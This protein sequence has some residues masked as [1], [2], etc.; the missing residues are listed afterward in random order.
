M[1]QL[2]E[3]SEEHNLHALS[4]HHPVVVVWVGTHT[5]TSRMIVPLILQIFFTEES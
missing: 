1:R 2:Y 5:T 3:S 4:K